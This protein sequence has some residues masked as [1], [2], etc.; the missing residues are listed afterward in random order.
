MIK[1][2]FY[3]YQEDLIKYKIDIKNITISKL[4][5]DLN[6]KFGRD[7]MQKLRTET[8]TNYLTA[9]RYLFIRNNYR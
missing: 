4:V 5:E 8:I 3:L 7:D 6:S 1:K 2:K 9:N